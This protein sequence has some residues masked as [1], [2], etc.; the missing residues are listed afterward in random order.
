MWFHEDCLQMSWQV[1]NDNSYNN[2]AANAFGNLEVT[3]WFED[4]KALSSPLISLSF[5]SLKPLLENLFN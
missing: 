5:S 1:C 4:M 2:V 3:Y